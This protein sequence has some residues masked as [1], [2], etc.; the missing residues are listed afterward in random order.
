[1]KTRTLTVALAGFAAVLAGC[2]SIPI[3]GEGL[4]NIGASALPIGPEKE[5]EIGFGI[6][7]TVVGRYHLVEDAELHRYVNLVGQS[8]A[9][10]SIRG[11]EVQF[12]F[13]VLD[14]DD[15]NAFAAPG[16]YILITRGALGLMESEADLAGVLAHEVGHVD[17]KHVL[18]EIRRSSVF[19]TVQEESELEG[20]LL[21]Q[22]AELGGSL[23]FMPG[24]SREDEMEA[25][26]LGVLY[27]AATGYRPDG[28]LNFLQRLHDA[29][30]NE[31]A[32]VREWMATHP[33][34]RDRIDAVA[35]QLA[36]PGI[37]RAAGQEVEERFRRFV[38]G[39]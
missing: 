37:D 13:G 20:P 6:A 18:D 14:T 4:I 10:Q 32:G 22:I 38:R 27:A 5:A 24:L 31:A 25:D 29:E 17:Q 36:R 35:R 12:S 33:S 8:V 28:I 19:E 15:V 16:G 1:M 26:S 7:A 39:G 9:Q 21:D 2:S 23:L 3:S 11:S 34:T 30:Q